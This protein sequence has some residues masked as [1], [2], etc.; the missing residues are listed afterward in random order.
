MEKLHDISEPFV[1]FALYF[2]NEDYFAET[3]LNNPIIIA[4]GTI[5]NE[6]DTKCKAA[7]QG[8]PKRGIGLMQ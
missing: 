5:N 1:V 6:N 4:F 8:R 3:A 7:I 2:F